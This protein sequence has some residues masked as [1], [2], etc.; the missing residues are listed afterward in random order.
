MNAMD[1]IEALVE[2]TIRAITRIADRV[3][4]YTTFLLIAATV[5]AVGSFL[6]GLA[7][8]SGGIRT[9]WIVLGIAFAAI[10]IGAAFT[11]RWRI[12]S[13]RRDV[14]ALATEVRSLLSDGKRNTLMIIDQFQEDERDSA[15]ESAIVVSRRV[16]ALRGLAADGLSSSAKLTSAITAITSF[17]GLALAAIA[18]TAVFG[19]LAL[20]FLLALALG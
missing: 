12:G 3:T 9:V 14:P 15:A 2:S 20:I 4:H 5:V 7:A 8:L 6:L 1:E 13:V 19:G 18:I 16:L 11:A 10:A 17:P